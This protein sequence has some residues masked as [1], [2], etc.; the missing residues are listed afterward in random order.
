M[1]EFLTLNSWTG[2]DPQSR[3][4]SGAID[5]QTSELASIDD[6]TEASCRSI[7]R[8]NHSIVGAMRECF[9]DREQR[10]IWTRNFRCLHQSNPLK[11]DG[12]TNVTAPSTA[13]IQRFYPESICQVP[14]AVT[15]SLSAQIQVKILLQIDLNRVVISVS[16]ISIRIELNASPLWSIL[17]VPFLA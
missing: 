11:F 7:P 9:A 4:R 6:W 14:T 3:E 10:V 15:Q 16:V 5:S 13:I 8:Q 2:F 12:Q 17:S 1:L